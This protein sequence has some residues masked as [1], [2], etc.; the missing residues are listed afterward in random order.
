MGAALTMLRTRSVKLHFTLQTALAKTAA[1]TQK[2]LQTLNLDCSRWRPYRTRSGFPN[3][4]T[5]QRQGVEMP[6]SALLNH[7]RHA[8]WDGQGYRRLG[9]EVYQQ[10]LRWTPPFLAST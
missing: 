7:F 3:H 10:F 4:D 8:A 5:R 1:L 6:I 9:T 2:I